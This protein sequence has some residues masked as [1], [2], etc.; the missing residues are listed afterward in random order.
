MV[1]AGKMITGSVIVLARRSLIDL[2]TLAIV[3]ISMALLWKFKKKL[4][5]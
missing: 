3:L 4:P 1:Q 5:Y 2:P